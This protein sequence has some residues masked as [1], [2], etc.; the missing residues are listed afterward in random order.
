MRNEGTGNIEYGKEDWGSVG[1]MRGKGENDKRN[2]D[3]RDST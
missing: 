2:E 3:W 1:S